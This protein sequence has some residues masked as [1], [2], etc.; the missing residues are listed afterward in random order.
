MI[1]LEKLVLDAL[2]NFEG[3]AKTSQIRVWITENCSEVTS[4]DMYQFRWAQQSLKRKGLVVSSTKS[5]SGLWEL[6][7][8]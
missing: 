8:D 3:K 4:E 6:I 2:I 7:Y 1:D 5:K